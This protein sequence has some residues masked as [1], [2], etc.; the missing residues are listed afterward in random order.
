MDL[1]VRDNSFGNN[2]LWLDL[3][4]HFDEQFTPYGEPPLL[5]YDLNWH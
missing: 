2:S 1:V 5:G 3:L 4:A